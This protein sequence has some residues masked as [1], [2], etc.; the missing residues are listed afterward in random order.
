M[1]RDNGFNPMRWDCAEQ[2]CFNHKKRPKI[3]LFADCLPGRIAFS[4]IDAIA[5]INGNLLLL[6]WKD[7]FGFARLRYVR[8]VEESKALNDL[9]GPFVVISASGMC[10]AG[11]ILHHLWNNIE[12]PKNTVLI[13]GYQAENTLGRKLAERWKEVPI[14]GEKYKLNAEVV[15]FDEFSGHADQ[16]DLLNWVA[17]G[18][19]KKIFIVH[20][21]KEAAELFA[22][23]LKSEGYADV[24]VPKLGESFTV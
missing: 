1:S 3:E 15:V 2:G 5:E 4:D 9:R 13:V 10:E 22:N 16:H 18:K 12:N 23:I 6:E 19:W 21:E 11:R 7:P 14:F 20:G 8:S 17:H 24:N